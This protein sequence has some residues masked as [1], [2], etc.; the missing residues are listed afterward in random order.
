VPDSQIVP[1]ARIT[2]LKDAVG[3]V[4]SLA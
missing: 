1:D 4:D 2:S 3:F